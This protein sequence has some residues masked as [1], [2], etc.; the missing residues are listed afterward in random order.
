MKAILWIIAASLVLPLAAQDIQPPMQP[1]RPPRQ[2]GD[3]PQPRAQLQEEGGLTR[4]ITIRLQGTTTTGN[5]IDLELTGMG[6]NFT[7]QQ[8]VGKDESILS[9]RY[10]VKEAEGGYHVSYQIG[11]QVKVVTSTQGGATNYEFQDVTINGS[12]LCTAG[13]PV[14][15]VRNGGKPLELVVNPAGAAVEG[16]PVVPPA[17]EGER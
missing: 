4:N 3:Q 8:I 11:M 5:E 6:P 13:K 12:A 15:I 2:R 7:A 1:P 9:C 17:P 16:K 14:V 10:G